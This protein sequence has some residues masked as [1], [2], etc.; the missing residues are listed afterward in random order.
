VA[1]RGA[2]FS[3]TLTAGSVEIST[4]ENDYLNSGTAA[5]A[6]PYL[7]K[8]SGAFASLAK[9]LS[10]EEWP[11]VARSDMASFETTFRSLGVDTVA[12]FNASTISGLAGATYTLQSTT[13]KEILVG[14]KVRADLSLSQAI[15]SPI[16]TT[17]VPGAIGTTQTIHD[18][19]DDPFTVTAN[20]IFD[21]A[22]AATGS[23]LPDSGYRFVAVEV[24]LANTST[25]GITDDANFAMT[26]TG[27]DGVTYT[28]DFGAVSEC[29]NFQ[30]GSGLFELAAG[31]NTTGCVIF[32]LPTAVSVQ[33]ISFSLA[34][35]YLDTAE[36]SN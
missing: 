3:K 16:A 17:P 23:G 30:Y 28:A 6:Q 19:Y 1:T 9:S 12:V 34:Q 18:F 33:T 26:V 36:W 31:D 13:N 21:P 11:S 15:V 20:Q 14:S 29:T 35:G 25:Q 27:S 4:D 5:K 10:I 8:L 2:Y 32:E 22:T 7:A 24:T